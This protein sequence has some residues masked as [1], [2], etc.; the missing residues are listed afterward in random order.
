[1]RWVGHVARMASGDMHREFW[2]GYLR[3]RDHLL[4]PSY[5]WDY[6]IKMDGRRKNQRM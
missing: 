2:W 4:T 5:R 3:E 6:N 1:M